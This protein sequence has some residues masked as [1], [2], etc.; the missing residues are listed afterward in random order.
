MSCPALL[1][2]PA[3]Q[4]SDCCLA[5][6]CDLDNM[7][8]VA[9]WR[10]GAAEGDRWYLSP[11]ALDRSPDHDPRKVRAHGL[12]WPSALAYPAADTFHQVDI[13]ALGVTVA[14]LFLGLDPAQLQESVRGGDAAVRACV[15]SVGAAPELRSLQSFCC[16]MLRRAPHERELAAAAL[17]TLGPLVTQPPD[18]NL[19]SRSQRCDDGA[20][21]SA[22][23]GH[24]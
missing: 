11:E 19:W 18:L 3:L 10:A 21:G 7:A 1:A 13:F 24:G 9:S 6:L 8:S 2:G 12:A 16:L 22:A 5:E 23:A 14:E 17:A 15:M 4:L 20:A